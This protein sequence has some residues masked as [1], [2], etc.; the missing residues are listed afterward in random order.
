MAVNVLRSFLCANLWF[1]VN[2][3]QVLKQ[4][5]TVDRSASR[6]KWICEPE[7]L[8][9]FSLFEWAN[10]LQALRTCIATDLCLSESEALPEFIHGN[11]AILAHRNHKRSFVSIAL[12]R[13]FKKIYRFRFWSIICEYFFFDCASCCYFCKMKFCEAEICHKQI[14]FTFDCC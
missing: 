14:M 1:Y 6:W 10:K 4:F 13:T 7:I 3:M 2:C 9:L 5:G 12:L 11:F 8:C